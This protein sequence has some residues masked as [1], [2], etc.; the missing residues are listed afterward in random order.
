NCRA[1]RTL[2]FRDSS[3]LVVSFRLVSS[4]RGPPL[5]A[6][7]PTRRDDYESR[8]SVAVRLRP[9]LGRPEDEAAL[10]IAPPAAVPAELVAG[11]VAEEAA[12]PAEAA[13]AAQNRPMHLVR[14]GRRRPVD[15]A[16]LERVEP[17]ATVRRRP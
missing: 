3:R 8:R 2:G 9:A 11:R 10:E 17:P 13:V 7:P 4:R 15:H 12:L 5:G 1:G 16:A 6:H 14:A